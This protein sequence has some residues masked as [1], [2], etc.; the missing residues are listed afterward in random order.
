MFTVRITSL[1]G[2]GGVGHKTGVIGNSLEEVLG[3]V[4]SHSLQKAFKVGE[5][6]RVAVWR[7]DFPENKP[8]VTHGM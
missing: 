7:I 2:G 1:K 3:Q 5:A 8:H 4:S 6:A